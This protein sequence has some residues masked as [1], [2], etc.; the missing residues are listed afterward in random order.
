[1]TEWISSIEVDQVKVGEIDFNLVPSLR[2]LVTRYN[3][4]RG[5]QKN[6]YVHMSYVY[7]DSAA[8]L[9]SESRDNYEYNKS[10]INYAKE[11]KKKSQLIS[12]DD[13]KQIVIDSEEQVW[14]VETLAQMLGISAQ[15]VR[16]RILKGLIP[17]HKEGR[18]WYVLKSEYISNLRSKQKHL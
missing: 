15:G 2:T 7:N 13:M 6:I 9:V 10:N 12:I 16:K 14:T 8:V 5:R 4:T 1:M 17:A 3:N 18:L 11:W